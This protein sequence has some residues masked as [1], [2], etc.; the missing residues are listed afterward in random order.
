[1]FSFIKRWYYRRLFLKVYFIYL[2]HSDNPQE[3][4]NDAYADIEAIKHAFEN[5]L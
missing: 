5:K 4:V 2:K 3:A 1:M